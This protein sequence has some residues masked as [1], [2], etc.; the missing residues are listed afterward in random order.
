VLLCN[1][2]SSHPESMDSKGKPLRLTRLTL[3]TMFFFHHGG[4]L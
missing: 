1:L 4:V 2:I 3:D